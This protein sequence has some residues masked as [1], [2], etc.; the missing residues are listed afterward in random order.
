MSVP[1]AGEFLLEQLGSENL[2]SRGRAWL[3]VLEGPE[4]WSSLHGGR[5]VQTQPS[6]LEETYGQRLEKD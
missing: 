5:G 2:W 6:I 1:G 4:K 3:R